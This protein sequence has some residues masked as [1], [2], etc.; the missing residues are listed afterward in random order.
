[1]RVTDSDLRSYLLERPA[2][3]EALE[4]R[5]LDDEDLF[6]RLRLVED[7][8]FD[9]Y[10][11][12]RLAASER[13]LFLQRYGHERTRLAFAGALAR[14][15][16]ATRTGPRVQRWMPLAAAAVLAIAVGAVLLRRDDRTGV[17]TRAAPPSE[18][19]AP[20]AGG[21]VSPPDPELRLTLSTVRSGDGA[22]TIAVP[23]G[24][25]GLVLRVHLDPAD[26]FESYEMEVRSPANA[27]VWRRDGL[28]RAA[29]NG[30]Y[31][32]AGTVPASAVVDG[33]HEVA[34]HGRGR[35]GAAEPLGFVTVRIVKRQ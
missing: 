18:T 7:E 21:A 29:A 27:V 6:D 2:D 24:A 33:N 1:M 15:A 25:R 5:L 10:V 20:S 34:V 12:G 31:S 28:R 22:N 16:Q 3:A 26:A 32:I 13:D 8:L 35:G 17:T 30:D 23:A 9:E 14:K 19:S 11:N 4:A